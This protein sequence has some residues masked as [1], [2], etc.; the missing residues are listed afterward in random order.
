MCPPL[1]GIY[2]GPVVYSWGVCNA[3]KKEA[4]K[5]P[6]VQRFAQVFGAVY[7]LVGV[8]GFIPPLLIGNVPGVLGP[9]AGMLLALFAVNWFHNVAHLAIGAVGLAVYRSYSASKT[10]ALALGLAYAGLFLLGV[11]SADVATLGGLLPLNG[12]DDLLHIA[13]SLVAFA[14]YFTARL[15]E[16]ERSVA[17]PRA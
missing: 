14:A 16:S 8:A 6:I 10:Y 13:T 17:Q 11:L 9:F 7:V 3:L 15:P 1:A 2:A 5:M 4:E 12:F